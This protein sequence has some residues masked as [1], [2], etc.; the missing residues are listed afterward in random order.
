MKLE[1]F[2]E[3]FTHKKKKAAIQG[4]SFSVS[5]AG[6]LHAPQGEGTL[7]SSVGDLWTLSLLTLT[8]PAEVVHNLI[9]I[10]IP[11]LQT[12]KLRFTEV[13]ILSP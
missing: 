9:F 6:C 8:P 1:N 5:G 3:G 4:W 11:I 7:L 13:S 10:I 12:R 2:W